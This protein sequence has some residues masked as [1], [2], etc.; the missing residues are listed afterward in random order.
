MKK[1]LFKTVSFLTFFIPTKWLIKLS[2]KKVIYPFY[3][4]VSDNT[5][6]H[7]KHLYPVKTIKQFEKD[8]D[9]LQKHFTASVFPPKGKKSLFVLSFD[10]GLKEI[11]D[12]VA[13]ILKKRNI[14]A[15]IFI[16]TSFVDN[17]GIFDNYI[18]S[19]KKENPEI[20]IKKYLKNNNPYLTKQQILQLK[21]E[22]FTVG[23]H[24]VTHPL[25]ADITERE[26]INQV[27]ESINF[28]NE[29]FGEKQKLFAFPFSD[30]GVKDTFFE[31]IFSEKIA[32]YTFG[33][34]GIKNDIFKKNIQ[35]IPIEKYGLS[36]KRHIKTDCLLY[37]LK[38]IIGKEYVKR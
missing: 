4:I 8:L 13:P 23:A 34:A 14:P 20:D 26:Q 37:I 15:I 3:H 6:A 12:I 22:G 36:A 28:V 31:T 25:F 35:R 16:N 17:K 32:D 19:L 27:K 1:L 18:S 5:P 9:F 38:K 11:Y 2:G 21:T 7:I 30:Y 10:D 29:I 33:T 24:G